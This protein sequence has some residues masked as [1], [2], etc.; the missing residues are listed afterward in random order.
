MARPTIDR[1]RLPLN[2]LRAFEA[3]GSRLSFTLGANSLS[4]TQSVVSR[5]IANLED[6]LGRKLIER[7]PGGIALTDAGA[8][9]LPALEKSLGL[10]E[11]TVNDLIDTDGVAQRRL[12]VR[13]PPTFLRQIGLTMIHRFREAFPD[14]AIDVSTSED[15]TEPC[16][17]AI[18][19]DRPRATDQVRD[20][21]WMVRNTPVCAPEIAR[22]CANMTL[23]E[24]LSG[25][26]L[27]HA[28]NRGER[29]DSIWRAFASRAGVSCPTDRGLTF[30]TGSLAVESAMAGHGVAL[31]DIVL[32][33]RELADGGL[34]APYAEIQEEGHGYFLVFEPGG[35]E[36]DDV[37][38][39]RSWIIAAFTGL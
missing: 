24:F 12:T 18:V 38:A 31:A 27:L 1:R 23:G 34:V 22:R 7:R 2:A 13:M 16:A 20:I 8:R 3:V 11:A 17:A 36:D 4:V 15:E 10:L 26:E 32:F 5:H 6:L 14:I 9:L 39:F 30:D 19:H 25:N 21:L 29:R 33:A 37:A 35:L 28:R